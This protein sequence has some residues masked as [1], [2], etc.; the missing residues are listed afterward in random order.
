[1]LPNTRQEYALTFAERLLRTV[2]A[3]PVGQASDAV[4]FIIRIGISQI[5]QTEH[6]TYRSSRIETGQ[7][8]TQTAGRFVFRRDGLSQPRLSTSFEPTQRI[9]N[10]MM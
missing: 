8:C 1:M 5:A 2:A 4:S 9:A 10:T 3:S 6:A 7:P